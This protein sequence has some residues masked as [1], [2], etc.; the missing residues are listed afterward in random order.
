MKGLH[1]YHVL[2]DQLVGAPERSA[3][4][5]H[6]RVIESLYHNVTAG[7]RPDVAMQVTEQLLVE[8]PGRVIH[9]QRNLHDDGVWGRLWQSANGDAGQAA[10]LWYAAFVQPIESWVKA[11]RDRIC[12]M[13]DN[14]SITADLRPYAAFM[15]AVMR[16]CGREGIAVGVGRFS[17][18]NPPARQF[19]QLA[20]MFEALVYW[21]T[22]GG[23]RHLYTP[24]EY[25]D[26]RPE[27]SIDPVG[28]FRYAV[29]YLGAINPLP[30]VI[31]EFGMAIGYDPHKG[32]RLLPG[33]GGKD[34]AV[35]V[36]GY[37]SSIYA[38]YGVPYCLYS[39]GAWP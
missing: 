26:V 23:V 34:Y 1:G 28:H 15:A 2:A 35:R 25:F 36:L 39:W 13:V 5:R 18:H 16:R 21:N 27:N 6:A 9:R 30:I 17:T 20:E 19:A 29:P 3:F 24:N 22:V 12:L 10:Q 4:M 8:A 14:E 11:R 31:G 7:S 37:R 32:Y 38:Q 33:Y